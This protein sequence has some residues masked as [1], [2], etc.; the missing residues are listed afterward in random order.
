MSIFFQPHYNDTTRQRID[1]LLEHFGEDFFQ[2]KIIA[3]F[4]AGIGHVANE[5]LKLGAKKI[6]AFEGRQENITTG[7]QL[8]PDIEFIQHDFTEPLLYDGKE[9]FDIVI[10]FGLIYHL[11]DYKQ[12]L[13]DSMKLTKKYVFLDTSLSKQEDDSFQMDPSSPD[14]SLHQTQSRFPHEDKLQM[15]L[16]SIATK[17]SRYKDELERAFSTY[18][19][20]TEKIDEKVYRGFWILEK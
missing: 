8:Y 6:V 3:D 9:K 2:G 16:E 7:K 13:E 15:F 1:F 4:G 5:L 19:R 20:Y 14:Q 18:H 10:N 12:C 17:V 11:P